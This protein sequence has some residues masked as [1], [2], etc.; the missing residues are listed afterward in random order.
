MMGGTLSLQLK[1][2]EGVH[3]GFIV[4]GDLCLGGSCFD[5]DV[6]VRRRGGYRQE[7]FYPDM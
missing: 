3:D 5:S 7:P 2:S 4:G 1:E 6:I